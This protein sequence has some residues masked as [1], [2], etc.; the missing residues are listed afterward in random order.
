MPGQ[1]TPTST[2]MASI[3][4]GMKV[5]TAIFKRVYRSFTKELRK[6]YRLN[7]LYVDPQKYVDILDDPASAQDYQ[8]PSNDIVPVADPQ[9]ISDTVKQMK[10]EALL[11]RMQM[12]TLNGMEVTKR[13]L[14]A[15]G[16][17]DI[18]ALINKEP[19]PP[20]PEAQK[21][22]MEM[23]IKQQEAQ[24]KQQEMQM[25]L[26]VEQQ[27]AQ[28]QIQVEQAKLQIEQMKLELEQQKAQFE[29]QKMGMQLNMERESNQMKQQ[30]DM[31]QMHMDQVKGQ[32]KM[33]SDLRMMDHKEQMAKKGAEN[34]GNKGGV[35]SVDSKPSNSSGVRGN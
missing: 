7:K 20:P 17:P 22:Q 23:Q 18:D 27:M 14:E 34:A 5:F 31:Q 29:M 3:E 12:G 6:I 32:F 21:M 10:A 1:N 16:Q 25:K 4:Q 15:Q 11:Q 33:E 8:G 26:Q 28:I 24:M 35:R 19:P 2:T 9:A 30:S 13:V